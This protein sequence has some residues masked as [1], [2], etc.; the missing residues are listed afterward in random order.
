MEID[1]L[2]LKKI[3]YSIK[4]HTDVFVT[5]P[6]VTASEVSSSKY[7][8][9]TGTP[10]KKIKEWCIKGALSCRRLDNNGNEISDWRIN[11]KLGH[12]Y[13]DTSKGIGE[14]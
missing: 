6:S 9:I 12:W 1:K 11:S 5:L 2:V 13:I 7:A 3:E 14:F 8:D 10:H 4:Y